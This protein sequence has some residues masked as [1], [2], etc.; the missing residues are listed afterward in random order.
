MN[1]KE[2]VYFIEWLA[3]KANVYEDKILE[4]YHPDNQNWTSGESLSYSSLVSYSNMN[5]WLLDGFNW[6][7]S[8]IKLDQITWTV[9]HNDWN[10]ICSNNQKNIKF[11]RYKLDE[12][13]QIIE[14][15]NLKFNTIEL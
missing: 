9:I 10:K 2:T 4:Q 11:C 15:P 5:E 8:I 6:Q 13:F 7:Y 14:K 3:K 1:E 12:N